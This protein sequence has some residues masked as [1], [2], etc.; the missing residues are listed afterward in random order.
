MVYVLNSDGS[1]LM[2]CTEAKARH[3]IE[4]GK[5]KVVRRTPFIIRLAFLVE[6]EVNT[7]SVTLGVDAGSSVIG[8]SVTT[9]DRVLL[10]AEVEVRN[11]VPQNM[12][13]RR[14]KRSG[15]RN[16]KTRYREARFDNRRSRVHP[17]TSRRSGIR[18]SKG[19]STSRVSSWATRTSRPM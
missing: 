7:E 13:E 16:R 5:A 4:G 10:E 19:K 11:D 2:P 3:L 6:G 15:R 12:E 8:V 9:E 14:S 1:P 17:S 18:E